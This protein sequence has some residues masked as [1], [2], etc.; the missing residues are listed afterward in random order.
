MA[1]N[2]LKEK[3]S[4]GEVAFGLGV[5]IPDPTL[6]YTLSQV[7]YDFFFLDMEHGPVG[8]WNLPMFLVALKASETEA[9]VRVPW[10]DFVMVKQ[11]LDLGV[12]NLVFPMINDAEA[13]RRAVEATR[14]PPD[15]I[16]GCGPW[17]AALDV[18][19]AEYISRANEEIGVFVQIERVQ[20]AERIEEILSVEGVTG[21][22][23]GPSDMSLSLGM[24]PDPDHPDIVS[25]FEKVMDV[26]REHGKVGGIAAGTPSRARFWVGRGAR[27][28]VVGSDRGLLL[29]E[30][31]E[32]L[33][34]ARGTCKK[35]KSAQGFG[36]HEGPN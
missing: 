29:E 15:G 31:R 12:Y 36:F 27:L 16:R 2:R 9:V 20:A 17:M 10:N 24:L 28:V 18:G 23:C 19:C 25:R 21:T 32:A 7:G 30:A 33:A 8:L 13:A 34:A 5:T 26:C 1:L 14:Y 11:V 3:F 35:A 6:V 22:Y 4:R